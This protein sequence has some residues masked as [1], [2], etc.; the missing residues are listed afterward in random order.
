MSDLKNSGIFNLYQVTTWSLKIF[1]QVMI[2]VNCPYECLLEKSLRIFGMKFLQTS[3]LWNK[4][5]Q[6]I[7]SLYIH[8]LLQ[9]WCLWVISGLIRWEKLLLH[10]FL[11]RG[12]FDATRKWQ[13]MSFFLFCNVVH[14]NFTQFLRSNCDWPPFW[15]QTMINESSFCWR[16]F[17]KVNQIS[18]C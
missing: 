15:D 5:C 17:Y 7:L 18:W 13:S 9:I 3:D 4:K 12:V 6:V 10:V 8:W 1:K 14:I 11:V 2:R 16:C